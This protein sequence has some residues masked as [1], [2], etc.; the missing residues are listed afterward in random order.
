MAILEKTLKD[1]LQAYFEGAEIE[2]DDL[3]KDGEHYAATVRSK[4]F[5]GKSRVEQHQMVYEALR[6]TMASDL[7]ALAIKTEALEG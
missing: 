6:G 3:S 5:Q 1:L 4:T 7:H 2:I